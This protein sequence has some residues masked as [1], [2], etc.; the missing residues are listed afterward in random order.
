MNTYK[1]RTSI[2]VALCLAIGHTSQCFGLDAAQSDAKGLFRQPGG[3]GTIS[4]DEKG[5]FREPS[6]A[7]APNVDAT[8]ID[9]SKTDSTNVETPSLSSIKLEGSIEKRFPSPDDAFDVEAEPQPSETTNK[10][11]SII[12]KDPDSSF[13]RLMKKGHDDLVAGALKGAEQNY[14]LAIKELKKTGKSDLRLAKARNASAN[15]LLRQGKV[16]DAK[17]TFELALKTAENNPGNNLEVAKAMAG[18]AA[19]NKVNGDYKKAEKLYKDALAIRRKMTGDN[20][21]GMAQMLLDLGEVYRAQKLYAEGEEI[22]KLALDTLSKSK[23]VPDLTKAYFLDRTGLFFQD[24][25]KMPEA[26]KCFA[27][28]LEIKDKFSTLYTPVDGHR[29][30]LVYYRC[31]NG[32]PNAARVFTRGAE[33]EYLHIKDAV[34]V[35]TLTPQ[36]YGFDWQLLKAE[37]TIQNQGKKAITACGEAPTFTVEL[38]KRKVFGPLDSESI[39]RELGLRGRLMFSRLLHSADFAYTSSS[40]NVAST[41]TGLTPFGAGVMNSV[42]SWTTVTPDW[43]ART[44]A[45]DAAFSFLSQSD[46]ET[47]SVLSTKPKTL[48]IGPGESATFQVFFPYEKFDAS[49]LRFLVGNAVMEFPFTNKSG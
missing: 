37:I 31:E 24:Q 27:T 26:K 13:D 17:T 3:A 36:E 1:K 7:E 11:E 20:D 9:T 43:G 12:F 4:G 44:A 21:S 6:E 28:A 41:S 40:V 30:G 38:P 34:A 39:A 33:I 49:V 29:R 45:R 35:A 15:V 19:V 14:D 48:T 2:L 22:Y 25:A 8:K 10:L 47:N 23:N 42:G 18:L 16:L 32:V 5:L 46:A